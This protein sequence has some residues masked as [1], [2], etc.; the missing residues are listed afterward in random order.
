VK[1]GVFVTRACVR[2][3]YFTSWRVAHLRAHNNIAPHYLYNTSDESQNRDVSNDVWV[4][5]ILL[6]LVGAQW[7][8][9]G[10]I[11]RATAGVT[12]R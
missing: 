5:A 6:G 3:F 10:V 11:I 2:F 7:V 12:T 9:I 8:D 1:F 4:G